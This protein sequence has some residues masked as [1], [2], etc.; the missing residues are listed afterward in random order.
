MTSPDL[1]PALSSPPVSP[2]SPDSGA[3]TAAPAPRRPGTRAAER[4]GAALV[5]A[6]SALWGTTGTAATFA[7]AGASGLSVGAAT[8]GLGGLLTLALAG[9][10][11][12]AVLRGGRPVVRDA[13]L[14]AAGVVVYPLAFYTSMAWAGVAVGTVVSLGCAP[15]FAA[16]MQRL[17]GGPRLG[18]RWAAAT[19]AAALGCALLVLAGSGPGADGGR[20]PG[21]VA[22]GLLAGAAYA[23]YAHC[24]AR[25]IARGHSSRAA[26]GTLFGLGAV[27]LLPVLAA[28]GR[29]LLGSAAGV[30]VA[31]Y[32]AVVPM[33]LA[34]VLFGA[35]LARVPASTAT[36][37]SLFEPV[38]AAVLGVVVVGERLT[39]PA[40]AG[41]ALVAAGLFALTARRGAA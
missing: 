34:Y 27:V 36:V 9:R 33:C 19:A 21:G 4:R 10:S 20:V 41:V 1:S 5:L 25:I 38:V 29:P 6:A 14:G 12:A 35:G 11:A 32:L 16:V 30:A 8:M 28:T 31:A 13:L 37:L 7:P 26:M 22:L 39:G 3:A 24:G 18:G 17:S 2:A 40:W 23:G 15:V